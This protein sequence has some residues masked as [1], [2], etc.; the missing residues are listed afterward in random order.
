MQYSQISPNQ[1]SEIRNQQSVKSVALSSYFVSGR[2][3]YMS[4]RPF[5]LSVLRF[6]GNS[7]FTMKSTLIWV[8]AVM[9]LLSG[10]S[11]LRAGDNDARLPYELVYKIQQTTKRFALEYTNLSVVVCLKSQRPTVK[12]GD[13]DVHIQTKAGNYPVLLGRDGQFSVPMRPEWVAENAFLIVNQP[14]GTMALDWNCSLSGAR[15]TNQMRYQELM[16]GVKDL[17]AV[18]AEVSKAF[19]ALP[20]Q[21]VSGLKLIFAKD[22]QA[23]VIVKRAAGVKSFKPDT[24]NVII[25]PLDST[26][27][28]ENPEVQ[29]KCLPERAEVDYKTT[30]Q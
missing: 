23:E 22:K 25:V 20:M 8:G 29:L 10:A 21:Q 1:Q 11:A 15:L 28:N 13:L 26:L 24:N 9:A 19:P 27:L 30:A 3:S 2:V 4:L 5:L 16:L 6:R 17:P 14:A 18:K 7:T 12:T